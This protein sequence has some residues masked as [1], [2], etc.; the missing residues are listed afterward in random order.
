VSDWDSFVHKSPV[1]VELLELIKRM[2]AARHPVLLLGERGTGKSMLARLL[3]HTG[4][5]ASQRIVEVNCS[6][7]TPQLAEAELFGHERGAFTGAVAARAGFFEQANKGTLFLDEVG[8]LPL[9]VQAQL[10]TVVE[11]GYLRRVGADAERK[12]DVRVISATNKDLQAQMDQGTFLPDLLDRLGVLKA[13]VPPLRERREDVP[14]LAQ[15]LYSS[16]IAALSSEEPAAMRAQ[17]K[18]PD[19]LP[20]E[21]LE[22]LA[23]EDWP[24]NVRQLKNV[25]ENLVTF[26]TD[27]TITAE[28]VEFALK[29]SSLPASI[30]S[31]SRIELPPGRTLK[32]HMMELEWQFIDDA[33]AASGGDV[34]QAAKRL[35]M[36]RQNLHQRLQ[37]RQTSG[38]RR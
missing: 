2:A 24:G 37:A 25:I 32:A 19:E 27:G 34:A 15:S 30:V 23:E 28:D 21:V 13:V 12:V 4:P 1:M 3:H 10:L 29:Q 7:I 16:S 26:N 14:R 9:E 33:L 38:H 17:L 18:Y 5:R 6:A 36:T 11:R 8:N 22:R 31:F 20:S 35:G